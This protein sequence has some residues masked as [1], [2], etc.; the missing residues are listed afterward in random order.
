MTAK[1]I[2]IGLP[3][4]LLSPAWAVTTTAQGQTGPTNGLIAHLPMHGD[5]DDISGFGMHGTIMGSPMMTTNRFG[6]P[7]QAF[8]FGLG[9]GSIILSNL[10]VNLA[11]N[12]QNT[13]C[14]WMRWDG[15]VDGATN[16]VAMPFGWGNTNQNYCLLFQREGTNRFGFSGGMGDVFGTNQS[17]MFS[18]HWMQVSA[19][20]NNGNMMDSRLYLNGQPVPGSMTQGGMPAGMGMMVRRSVSTNAFIGGFAGM[21]SVPY[22]FFGAMSD[23]RIYNRALTDPEIAALYEMDAAPVMQVM[24]GGTA[25]AATITLGS[26]MVDWQFQ[27]QYSDDLVHWTNY[28]GSFMPG[29]G[30]MSREV[31]TT[32]PH[33]FWRMEAHP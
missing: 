13:V 23:L 22:Q 33:L 3:I 16:P 19:V 8:D 5:A 6:E 1:S 4:L 11:T 25:G 18:N 2:R 30:M 28:S 15:G 17:L 20:F 31:S 29:P 24:S 14:F 12:S 32:D 10:P 26:L 7:G 21:G 27:M 9:M